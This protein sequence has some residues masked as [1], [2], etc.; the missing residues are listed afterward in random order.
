MDETGGPKL[1]RSLLADAFAVSPDAI[2]AT[3]P[4]GRILALN[5]SAER[6][7]G[8]APGAAQGMA[9]STLFAE[10]EAQSCCDLT[11]R[12]VFRRRDGGEFL[13]QAV[14]ACEGE[15]G[16]VTILRDVSGEARFETA[17][18]RLYEVSTDP[19]LSSA[20]RIQ[21]TLSLGVELFGVDTGIVSY[22]EGQHYVVEQCVSAEAPIEPGHVF[23]LG[24]TY[25]SITLERGEPFAVSP[26]SRSEVSGHPAFE[27][28]KLE[29]YIGAP[30]A[31]D[32]RLFGTVAFCDPSAR[33]SP[34]DSGDLEL[35]RQLALRVGDELSSQ[36]RMREL[37]AARV[38]AEALR[39]RA[40]TANLAKSR[41]LANMSHE[42]RTP[43]NGVLGM[44]Q[45]LQ[46]TELDARQR[47]YAE[48]IRTSGR[49][50][51][52]LIDDV[53]DIS[54]IEAGQLKLKTARFSP[55]E[56]LEQAADT[57]RAGAEEKGLALS[58]ELQPD[59]PDLVVGDE[60]RIRQV[61]INLLGNAVKFT[62]SGEVAA[63][64]ERMSD[65]RLRFSVRDTGPGVPPVMHESIFER[66]RQAD[67]ST[68]RAHDGAGLGLAIARDLVRLMDGRIGLDS[69]PG[70]GALFFFELPLA[71][72]APEAVS[73][74]APASAAPQAAP[75]RILVVDD[76]AVSREVA[77]LG[78]RE[79]GYETLEAPGGPEALEIMS[80]E[81]ACDLVVLD[82]HMPD[83][84]GEEV[85][86]R[87]RASGGA[88]AKAPIVFLTADA[89]AR[90]G[91]RL[92]G[93]GAAARL[94]KPVDLDELAQTVARVL[95][96]RPSQAA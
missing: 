86:N 42:I 94:L 61:L 35:I 28:Q 10:R 30:L 65:G 59:V 17:L 88:G 15:D 76:N 26:A 9:F 54:R 56:L 52:G 2:V 62:E 8:F 93:I 37:E 33:P 13:A 3:D 19:R 71:A 51:L 1:S 95:A 24:R 45:L 57:V 4:A 68:A 47:L 64:V 18:R 69:R 38:E 48:T 89:D 75:A 63:K 92:E 22:V 53:L 84:A 80:G 82:L 77:A 32:G 87:L 11:R 91:D 20:G 55:A 66:F 49:A 27:D 46:R 16:C 73:A 50:L 40:E 85:F 31:V 34:F 96:G 7:F 29:T 23:Q 25:C 44:A 21:A 41:F 39:E 67:A 81:A 72:G 43:L 70:E 74:E 14:T 6:L 79:H 36:R 5:P 90:V 12:S 58:V 60:A 78:L 83:I